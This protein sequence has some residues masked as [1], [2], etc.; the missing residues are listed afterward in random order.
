MDTPRKPVDHIALGPSTTAT[1]H[2]A[3][4]VKEG[5]WFLANSQLMAVWPLI[6]QQ[7]VPDIHAQHCDTWL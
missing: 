5:N 3:D 7:R 1:W 6:Q 2:V 4:I